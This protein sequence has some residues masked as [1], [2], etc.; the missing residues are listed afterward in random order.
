MA[1]DHSCRL[2]SGPAALGAQLLLFILALSALAWKR[3]QERPQR[4]LNIWSMDVSKQIVSGFAAHLCGI[5][6][7]MLA[8]TASESQAS[9]CAWYFFAFTFDTTLGVAVTILIHKAAIAICQ[10]CIPRCSSGWLR[11]GL[12]AVAECG[13]YGDPP[14]TSRFVIQLVEWTL[15][16]TLARLI[17]GTTVIA[18]KELLV[19][20]ARLLDAAFAGHPTALLYFVMVM[21]PLFMN[22]IQALIQD[23]VL[24]WKQKRS[25]SDDESPEPVIEKEEDIALMTR[26]RPLYTSGRRPSCFLCALFVRCALPARQGFDTGWKRW[27]YWI[28]RLWILALTRS[29]TAST[30]SKGGA[31]RIPIIFPC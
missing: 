8:S 11:S 5:I 29:C 12:F 30:A 3:H 28:S 26:S 16:M 9:E 7:A 23:A 13:S 18:A 14:Q 17:V 27:Q 19:D 24:K 2:L 31:R 4:P 20:A 22:L 1:E 25:T 21:C 15:A 6:I 10:W